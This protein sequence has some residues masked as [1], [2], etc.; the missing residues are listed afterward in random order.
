MYML[1][2]TSVHNVLPL[3][4]L[5]ARSRPLIRPSHVKIIQTNSFTRLGGNV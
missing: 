5:G 1:C 4:Y 2:T 3:L